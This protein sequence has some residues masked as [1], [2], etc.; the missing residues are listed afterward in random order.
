MCSI[1][2]DKPIQN[3]ACCA[4]MSLYPYELFV[5]VC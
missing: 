2:S 1:M 5:V 4:A 3:Q